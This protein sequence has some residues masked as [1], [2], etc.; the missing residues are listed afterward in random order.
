MLSNQVHIIFVI[1]ELVIAR[2]PRCVDGYAWLEVDSSQRLSISQIVVDVTQE[3]YDKTY[4]HRC[5]RN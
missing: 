2:T 4:S 5:L 3:V 1:L